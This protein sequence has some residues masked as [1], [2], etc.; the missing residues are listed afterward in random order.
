LKNIVYIYPFYTILKMKKSLFVA[1]NLLF[2]LTIQ[3]Q[4]TPIS[5]ARLR[6]TGTI[7][8]VSGIITNGSELGA[9]R[10][11][12]DKTG[13]LA[14]FGGVDTLKRGDSVVIS[15]KLIN[16]NNLLEIQPVTSLQVIAR[17]KPL[18][19]P[20]V[21]LF[22]QLADSLESQL[23]TFKNVNFGVTG[24]FAAARN[25][26][27]TVGT[28]K[29]QVRSG[30]TA[31]NLTGTLIPTAT[32][33]VTGILS[34]FCAT[35]F[36]GCTTG[37]QTLLRDT[38]DIEFTNL[39]FTEGLTATNITTTGFTVNWLT[40]LVGT[41]S[42]NYGTTPALGQTASV[43][44]TRSTHAVSLTSLTPATVY[45]VQSESAGSGTVIRSTITSFI[46][47]STS[48]GEMRVYFN[49]S[50]DSSFR[51]GTARPLAATGQRCVAETIARIAA[52]TQ[53]IDVAM[54]SSGEIA[55]RDA[56]KQAAARGVRVRYITD[57][58]PSN[59]P[60][61][62]TTGL[63]FKFVK[64]TNPNLMHNKFFVFDANSVDNA[65][66]STGSMNNSLGQLYNDP[67]NMIL[68]QDQA[69]ARVFTLEFDE[70]WGSTTALPN[71]ANAKYGPNKLK[72]TPK[73][74]VIGGGKNI[75]VYF[76]P[77]DGATDAIVKEIDNANTDLQFALLIHTSNET[78][79]AIFNAKRRNVNIRGIVDKDTATTG[80]EFYFLAR[81]GVS[82][83]MWRD[84]TIF[85]HKYCVIDGTNPASNPT[86]IT[87]SHNWS[88]AAETTNDEN[89]LVIH[90]A[91]IAN[92]YLQEFEARWKETARV[93]VKDVQIEGFDVMIYPNP[94]T[95]VA[96][97]R[98]N[99]KTQRDVSITL[100]NALGQVIESRILR[101]L[102]GET[103]IDYP[104]SNL[105]AGM[106]F[107]HFMVDGK[108]MSKILHVIK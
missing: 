104:L 88:A 97:V 19:A 26:D 75:E 79:T 44:G 28:T 105:T 99:N 59:T 21:V 98:L 95:Y 89:L 31:S 100:T 74:V 16:F 93:G 32:V 9:I 58:S 69:L 80:D 71:P 33:N 49:R 78:G 35:P 67:N 84:S 91:A 83:R 103:V 68:I 64:S 22:A 42:I 62:D 10:Y 36:L 60:F 66:V 86:L 65:W 43:T 30:P 96:K 92:I 47:A 46:T 14:A 70:M 4:V 3:A 107:L 39:A 41:T 40:N 45:Y 81:N 13:G 57:K 27:I 52:A 12:Q 56:L 73:N 76:S 15:G 55:I 8:T 6:D 101:N 37:Y 61:A 77:T 90:D 108:A 17:N 2:A 54:Y 23:V 51:V 29:T 102:S 87:G 7:V 5:A 53:T 94:A 34:Q 25:Y 38:A 106:Y 50:V 82:M 20:R 85:H 1:L 11:F 72:N 24:N 48:T 18:P 63:G